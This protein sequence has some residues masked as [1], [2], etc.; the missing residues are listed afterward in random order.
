MN[1]YELGA[2][3]VAGLAII[4]WLGYV[5]LELS[6]LKSKLLSSQEAAKDAN[7]KAALG[8]LSDSE[9]TALVKHDV[10]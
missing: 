8:K 3:A 7:T 10:G 4:S 1:Y 6:D 5:H 2:G 9:V